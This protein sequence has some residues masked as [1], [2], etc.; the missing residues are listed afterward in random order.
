MKKLLL[1]YLLLARLGQLHAD[2]YQSIKN[3]ASAQA[4]KSVGALYLET[5]LDMDVGRHRKAIEAVWGWVKTVSLAADERIV[6]IERF[7]GLE[8]SPTVY[9]PFGVDL[10]APTAVRVRQVKTEEWAGI[11]KAALKIDDLNVVGGFAKPGIWPVDIVSVLGGKAELQFAV[12]NADRDLDVD[13]IFAQI[14]NAKDH[15]NGSASD[16]KY[17]LR[18]II[19]YYEYRALKNKIISLGIGRAEDAMP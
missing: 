9:V 14:N 7:E 13:G 17:T 12:V 11:W 4:S 3:E 18:T 1:L 8:Y 19:A 5:L 2:P 6:I 15:A 16:D 10:V